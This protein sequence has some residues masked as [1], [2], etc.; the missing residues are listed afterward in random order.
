[1][2]HNI[3]SVSFTPKT[4]NDDFKMTITTVNGGIVTLSGD[5]VIGLYFHLTDLLNP[6][7]QEATVH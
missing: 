1:M 3:K 2:E 6:E 4:K 7:D 5:C